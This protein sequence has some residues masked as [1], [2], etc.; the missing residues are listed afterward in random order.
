MMHA[1]VLILLVPC[2]GAVATCF[3][4]RGLRVGLGV[5]TSIGTCG[6]VGLLLAH[7][8][9][10]GP[11]RYAIGGWLA[12]LGIVLYGDGLALL[13][14]LLT[15]VVGLAVSLYA[16]R[17]F[18]AVEDDHATAGLF[19]PLWLLL[20]GGLNA[21]FVS[22]DIFNLYLLL[23]FTLL[24]SVALAALGGSRAGH[25]SALRYLLAATTAGLF[26]LLG[27]TFLY[28][29][30]GT[31]DLALL[32][33]AAP[34]GLLPVV[35][36]W[37][38]IGALLL[39]CA[40]VPL[41]FWLPAAH[42]TA[43]APVSA[44]LSALV[45]KAG[46]YVILRIALQTFPDLA[47]VP[48]VHVLSALG[49]VA[50]LW[51]SWQALV[52]DRLKMLIAYSTVAQVGYLFLLLPLAEPARVDLIAATTYHMLSHGLAK[53]AFFLGTGAVVKMAHSDLIAHTRGSFRR[54]PLAVMAMIVSGAVL[55]GALPGGGAKGT[56]FHLALDHGHRIWAAAIAAGMVLA[57][58]YTIK[59]VRHCFLPAES[60]PPGGRS[61][62]GLELTALAL[63]GSAAALSFQSDAVLSLLE[64]AWR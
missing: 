2:A 42:S 6:A 20:W 14:L 39:K 58:A 5:A 62:R 43:P 23:E 33:A 10:E 4:G 1:I 46:F 16:A 21:L 45:V 48:A 61:S 47:P 15:A 54:A 24:A 26:Y 18:E 29:E 60:A 59:A 12:P 49:L 17:Y 40:L 8:L 36:L 50:L 64:I 34:S 22:G 55:A 9:A 52:Q 53:A 28:A 13:M 19:W 3:P 31:L 57:A 44:V 63:A 51:G 38:M 27:V 41:H 11:Q 37:S 35:A 32:R 56:L 25:V 7:L 30:A